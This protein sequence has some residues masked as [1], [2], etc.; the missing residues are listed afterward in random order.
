VSRFSIDH[1][2]RFT[3]HDFVSPAGTVLVAAVSIAFWAAS[4]GGAEKRAAGEVEMHHPKGWV[5]TM[6]KGD[7]AKGRAVFRK[8]ECY[9]CHEVRGENFP[10]PSGEAV[11]PELSQ[12]G[13]LHPLE[14]FTESVINP[15][16]IASKKYRGP[17][18][19]SKMPAFNED[20]S[21]Q[22]LIDLSAY[23]AS[24]RPKGVPRS[25]AGVGTVIALVPQERQL[26]VD[27][28]EIAG[29]M[30]AMVMGYR[31]R[32]NALLK[33]LSP[34]DKVRFTIDTEKRVITKVEKLKGVKEE[35]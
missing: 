6:P 5:F 2:R 23:L 15:S 19:R 29:F 26:V 21:V 4:A 14:Y 31:V 22:E 12:M 9:A 7:P 33:G 1:D 35:R 34:G 28:E 11:G 20:M 16:A 24:L 30:D 32:S 18:G 8:F 17:D 25:V 10:R 13:P 27:H 3:T